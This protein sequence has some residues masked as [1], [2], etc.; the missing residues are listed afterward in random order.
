MFRRDVD[1]C[2]AVFLLTRRE[3]FLEGGGFDEAF[4][5][6]YY[7]D[8]DYCVGL[9]KRGKRVVYDP[10]VSVLHYEFGSAVSF[11]RARRV[12]SRPTPSSPRSSRVAERATTI[13]SRTSRGAHARAAP[14]HAFLPRRPR[15]RTPGSGF[16]AATASSREL[17]RWALRHFYL[18]PSARGGEVYSDS[19]ASGDHAPGGSG[20]GGFWQ[21]ADY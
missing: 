18:R 9:W 17:S 2:S 12:Q 3:L 11:R 13:S 5:P 1:Y 19:R 21:R 15:A 16:P 7:E 10:R 14:N 20:V 4:A 6:A 8:A